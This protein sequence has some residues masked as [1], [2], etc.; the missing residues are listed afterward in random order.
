MVVR[1]PSRLRRLGGKKKAELMGLARDHLSPAQLEDAVPVGSYKLTTSGRALLDARPEVVA[2][3][4]K[5]D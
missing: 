4:P 2:K 3:H 1:L 5:K